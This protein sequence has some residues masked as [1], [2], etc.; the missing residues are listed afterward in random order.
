MGS[1]KSERY[2]RLETFKSLFSNH[3]EI[4]SFGYGFG[5]WVLSLSVPSIEPVAKVAIL[6]VL[7]TVYGYDGFCKYT[8]IE[9]SREDIP[10][11]IRKQKHYFLFG[12]VSAFVLERTT[13]L[14]IIP[15]ILPLIL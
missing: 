2:G 14:F 4:H 9:A 13:D 15:Y 11:D 1:G 12:I 5:G 10:I 3:Y 7:A 8:G 6:G